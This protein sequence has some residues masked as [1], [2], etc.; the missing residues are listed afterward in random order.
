MTAAKPDVGEPPSDFTALMQAFLDASKSI[1]ND[2]AVWIEERDR[3][4]TDGRL[5]AYPLP[6]DQG[7]QHQQFLAVLFNGEVEVVLGILEHHKHPAFP[8]EPH[9]V[10]DPRMQIVLRVMHRAID[11]GEAAMVKL[12]GDGEIVSGRREYQNKITDDFVDLMVRSGLKRGFGDEIFAL[13]DV[14]RASAYRSMA[15]RANRKNRR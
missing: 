9:D 12:F 13:G 15:R 10:H 4:V 14:S 2:P 7:T 6:V 5:L 1:W 3:N 11:K 8:G